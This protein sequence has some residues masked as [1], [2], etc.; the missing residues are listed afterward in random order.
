M[1]SFRRTLL[2]RYLS[3]HSDLMQGDVVDIGGKNENKRGDFRPLLSKVKSWRYVNIDEKTNPDYC[4]SADHIP[5]PDHAFD[6]AM[7]SE[8]L[9][10]LERPEDVLKEIFRIL[11]QGGVMICSMPFLFPIHGDPHDFQRWTETKIKKVLQEVGFLSISIT[12]M[13]S[14]G[15]VIHDILFVSFNKIQGR[16]LRRCSHFCLRLL[17]WCFY[18]L[19]TALISSE[20]VVTTGYF[21][22]ARK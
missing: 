18:L 22:S 8:V 20:N 3:A 16:F 13:G 9:E 1:K 11:K 5:V 15:S 10:H 17:R 12:P 7:F 19:D 14:T 2:D 6:T 21:I 4:C